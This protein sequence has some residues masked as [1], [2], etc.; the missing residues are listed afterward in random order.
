MEVR[1]GIIESSEPSPYGAVD[2]YKLGA[3]WLSDCGIVEDWG[4]GRGY[5]RTLIAPERYR[6]V[7][8]GIDSVPKENPFADS[9]T[10]LVDYQSCVPGVFIRHVLEHNYGWRTILRNAVGSFTKRLFLCVFT[11]LSLDDGEHVLALHGPPEY[12]VYDQPVPSLSLPRAGIEAEFRGLRVIY[13]EMETGTQ[14]GREHTWRV[15]RASDG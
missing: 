10:D 11:P 15:E 5:L 2:T 7:D 13:E 9:L 8:I 14:Y 4:C 12:E 3:E 6:G 1:V